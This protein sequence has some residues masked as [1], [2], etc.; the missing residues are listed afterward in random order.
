VINFSVYQHQVPDVF[1]K[2]ECSMADQ[3]VLVT[4]ASRG[5][6]AATAK[7]LAASGYQ[8]C[9]NYKDDEEASR[10]TLDEITLAGGKAIVLRA[11]VSNEKEVSQL[12]IDI[13][14]QLGALTALV[15]NVGRLFPQSRVLDMDAERI[16]AT[17][18]TNV[19]SAFLCSKQ[20]IKRMSTKLGGRGGSIVNVSSAASRLGSPHEYID[21]A[22]S[23]GAIDTFTKG[24][25]LELAEDGIRVNCVRPGFIY[26]DIHASG[27]DPSRIDR[28]RQTIPLGRGGSPLEVANA[29]KFLLSEDASYITGTFLDVAGGK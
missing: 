26:T 19:L 24:L 12:F 14:E 17:L 18:Q 13:D 16:M 8:V 15:N 22:A 25:S 21:Y 27:G 7:A 28:L 9:I 6:G 10:I 4:G 3:I 11:D 1:L 23:K 2:K 5:I 29:I 20:A